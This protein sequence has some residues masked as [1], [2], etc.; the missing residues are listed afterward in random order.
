VLEIR[1][2]QLRLA[3]GFHLA[4]IEQAAYALTHL[5]AGGRG[6]KGTAITAKTA[7]GSVFH[8]SAYYMYLRYI[9]DFK[10]YSA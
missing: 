10:D 2:L 6:R 7:P 8:E 1:L 9:S 4:G 3:S 5:S